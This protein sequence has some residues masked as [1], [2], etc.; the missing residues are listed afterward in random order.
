MEKEGKKRIIRILATSDTHNKHQFIEPEHLPPADIFI[1]AG[2]FT[3]MSRKKEL[4]K[5]RKFLLALPYKHKIVI[6]GNHDFGLMADIEKY[7][8]VSESFKV[9]D[10][11]MVDPF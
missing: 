8:M 2:D 7:K 10:K 1:H 11:E 4:E 3:R 6:P 5:F 9:K